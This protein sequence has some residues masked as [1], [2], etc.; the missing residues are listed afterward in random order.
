M[1]SPHL[2]FRPSALA[3]ASAISIV[4]SK[5]DHLSIRAYLAHLRTHIAP[6]PRAAALSSTHK[7]LDR[8]AY[9]R[10]EYERSRDYFRESEAETAELRREIEGLKVRLAKAR[11]D[12]G[13]A[14]GKRKRG[15]VVDEDVVLVPRSPKKAKVQGV[16]GTEVAR[17]FDFA[18]VGQSGMYLTLLFSATMRL[19]DHAQAIFC[20][21]VSTTSTRH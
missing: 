1:S 3:I 18:G 14:G 6:G 10:G 16:E 11:E 12:G 15:K 7:H 21:A 8:A 9:W 17:D 4:Q 19:I 5:P 20:C 13:A 2:P